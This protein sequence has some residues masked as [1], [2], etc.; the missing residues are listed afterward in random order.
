LENTAR[1]AVS[2]SPGKRKLMADVDKARSPVKITKH[3]LSKQDVIISNKTNITLMN[4]SDVRFL[5][6]PLLAEDAFVTIKELEKLALWQLLNTRASVAS[7]NEVTRHQGKDGV[8]RQ[9]Q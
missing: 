5:H 1:R 7:V 4:D 3:D 8:E 6:D 9:D 2:F